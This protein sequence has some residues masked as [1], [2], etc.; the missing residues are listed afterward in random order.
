VDVAKYSIEQ[1]QDG[2]DWTVL[3]EL[4]APSGQWDFFYTTPRLADLSSYAWRITPIDAAGNP[5]TVT[6]FTA[7]IFVRQ[8][9]APAFSVA[10]NPSPLTVTFDHA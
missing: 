6:T 2:G 9:D 8:P 5:G 1:Q 3:D 4:P 10:F 7:E